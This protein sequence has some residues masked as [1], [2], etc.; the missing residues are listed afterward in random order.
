MAKVK[1]IKQYVLIV[2]KNAKFHSSLLK[3]V[4]FSVKIAIVKRDHSDF[5]AIQIMSN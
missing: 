4:T 3:D 2:S 5:F 1:C